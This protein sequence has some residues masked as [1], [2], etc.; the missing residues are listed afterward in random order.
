[1]IQINL[2]EE[3]K[4]TSRV[5]PSFDPTKPL[6]YAGFLIVVAVV[7]VVDVKMYA[8]LSELRKE[9]KHYQTLR[10]DPTHLAKL[11]QAAELEKA[12]EVLNKKQVIIEDLIKNRIDWSKKLGAL[13]ENLPP[14]IWIERI[15][16]KNPTNPRITYQTLTVEAATL[17]Y[18]RGLFR[19]AETME[20]L[21]NS[22]EFMQ[23]FEGDLSDVESRNEPW[24][25]RAQEDPGTRKIWRFT[26]QAKRPLPPS[27]IAQDKK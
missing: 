23:G 18:Q 3:E 8:R 11:D 27:E 17:N 10:K 21:G 13:R 14:D 15:S 6:I 22:K 9:K 20:K 25:K 12:L 19:T 16:L 5:Q 26:F 4:R 1:M 2:L 7:L 24:D